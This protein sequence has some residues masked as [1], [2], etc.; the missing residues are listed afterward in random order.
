MAYI[1]TPRTDAGNATYMSNAH[2]LENFSVEPSLLSPLKRKDDLVSQMRNGRGVSLKTPRARVPFSDRRNLPGVPG[3][4][5]FTPLLQSVARKNLERNGKLSGGPETPAFL[6]A[7]Y[8]GGNTPALPGAEASAIYGS[9]FDSSVLVDGEGT[10]MPQVASSSSQSTPLA[11][12]PKR[13]ATGVLMDQGNLM[14]LREQENI[15]DKIEKENFGLKLKIHFLEDS[16]RKSGPGFNEAALKE[17][18]DLK[19]DRVTLQKDLARCKKTLSQ[20]E[21]DL[22]AYRRHVEELQDK[23]KRKYA[24]ESLRQEL[25]ELK[26]DVAKKEAEI[27]DLRQRLDSA[28]GNSDELEKL[29]GDIEDIEAD[30]REKE[31]SICQRDDEIDKLKEQVNKDSEELDEVYA[32]LE[33]GKKRIEE[34]EDGREDFE[35]KKAQLSGAKEELQQALEEKRKVEEEL[36]ELR[37]EVSNKSFTTRGLSRQLEGKANQLQD[38]LAS[39]RERHVELEERFNDKSREATKLK[40]KLQEADQDADVRIQRLKDENELLRDEQ[41]ASARKTEFL[42]TQAQEAVKELQTKA[43]EKDLIHSRH[44][45][46]TAESQALQKELSKAQATVQELEENLGDERRHAQDNDRQLRAEAKEGI[47]RLSEQIDSL[48]RELEDKESQY[49]ADQDHWESQKRGLQSQ[50]ERAEEQAAGLQRTISKLQEVEGTLSGREMKL[51]E[52]LESEKQR[53]KSEE[54]VIE[55]QVQELNA[56]IEEKRQTLDELR[57]ELSQT[58]ED[59]RVSQRDQAAFEEKVQALED[60]VDVL[61]TGLDEEADKARDEINAIEQRAEVLRSELAAAK[62]Q[63]SQGQDK[64]AAD[65]MQQIIDDM[66][67]KLDSSNK[68]LRQVKVEKQSLQDKLAKINLDMHALQVSSAETEAERDEI[69]SQLMQIQTQVDETYR[70]DQEKLDLRTSKL[71]IENDVGRLR[72]ERKGLLEKNAAIERELETEIARAIS[73]EGRLTNELSDLQRKLAAASGNRDRELNAARLKVQRLEARVEELRNLPSQD[74]VNEAAAELSMIQKD[75]SAAR[76]KEADYLQ[77]EVL[78]KEIV[79]D[80]KQKVTHLERRSHDL[81]VARL[82]V[83]SPKSSVGGS[84][85]ESELIEVQR[86]LADTHQQLRDARGKSK[87]DLR[88]LQRR[89]AESERQIQSNLDTYEQQREQLEAELSAARHEQETLTNR[90]S[91]AN[92]TITRLRTRISSLERDIHAHRQAATADNTIVEERKDLHEMLK[93]AKLTAE[94]LQ[95]QITARESQLATSSSREKELRASLKRIREER[96]LQAQRTAALSTEL[97]HLQTRYERSVDNL[98][99]QQRK[100]EEERKA[101]TTRVRFPNVSVSSLHTDNDNQS[102]VEQ[103]AAEIR[104]LAKQ[105]MWLRAKFERE[106]GFRAGLVREKRYMKLEI[107]QFEACNK[108]NLDQLAAIGCKLRLTDEEQIR[109]RL[110]DGARANAFRNGRKLPSIKVIALTIMATNRMK[111][112]SEQWGVH[113]ERKKALVAGLEKTLARRDGKKKGKRVSSGR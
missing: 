51:Q 36:D 66:Y 113:L 77:R 38:E 45:A 98:A 18:T 44:D 19:V 59:L 1:E 93:D 33:I 91:I 94:D 48:H 27:E 35:R 49:A 42:V 112:R 40:E 72:E 8:Q 103:H 100:W 101:M 68:E 99:R 9:D 47:D 69:K 43:E 89:L 83:D 111:K 108:I 64:E 31:R 3:R 88:A 107:A 26:N 11:V 105:I 29:K 30:L 60:E 21:R 10:P 20:A 76:K 39:L 25:E 24:D 79:R 90:N 104:G 37:D 80:L 58:R 73:E 74:N 12:L 82:T 52:A 53:H 5:E 54:A 2:N 15:I 13:D 95:V 63:L 61:Q 14:T 75:L 46:L 6:K 85:R 71:K 97:D 92:Q 86:Q 56:D 102:L 16:L 84:A 62:E 109:L 32:E 106:Q 87:D 78:Q 50:K 23:A 55:R 110:G 34:L 65:A 96:T 81:E 7:S 22:M 17:N 67:A 57:S 4:G 41:E 70:L 28:E